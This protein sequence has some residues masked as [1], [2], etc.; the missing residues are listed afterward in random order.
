MK[1][2]K[3]SQKRYHFIGFFGVLISFRY[4]FLTPDDPGSGD[5]HWVIRMEPE[6]QKTQDLIPHM[7]YFCC[8]YF[9]TWPEVS[10][11][12]SHDHF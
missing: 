5:L 4:P 2:M 10:K 9:L 6:H 12:W 8:S 3:I 1:S 7:T 11:F